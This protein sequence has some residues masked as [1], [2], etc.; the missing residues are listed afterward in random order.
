[1]NAVAKLHPTEETLRSFGLGKLDDT[2]AHTVS[3][4]LEDCPEC[5]SL[6]A[7]LPDDSFVGRFRG[8]QGLEPLMSGRSQPGRAPSD[9]SADALAPPPYSTLPPV[10]GEHSDHEVIRELGRGGM[11]VVYLAHNRLMGRDEVLKVV[12][13]HLVNRPAVLDRFLREIRSAAKLHHRYIVTAYSALRAG[14]HLVL[15][16]EYVEG[17]DLADLVKA[18]GPLPIAHACNFVFQAALG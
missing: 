13:G 15:A 11:G 16:M 2:S 14:E 5:R 7:E 6:V 8:A 18:N 3:Q 12:D 9:E 17:L 4:H 1:M 10:L